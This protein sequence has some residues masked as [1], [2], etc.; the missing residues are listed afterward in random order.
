MAEMRKHP[1]YSAEILERVARFRAFAGIAAAH[2]ERLDGQGYH[3]G[4]EAS[5]LCHLSR[6][7]AVADICEAL[8]AERPY[9]AALPR[10]EVLRMM[11]GMVDSAI[12]GLAFEGLQASWQ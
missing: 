10:D 4:L 3:L 11:K 5:D 1:R 6:I 2:H 9:R 8:S 7:L 12:C